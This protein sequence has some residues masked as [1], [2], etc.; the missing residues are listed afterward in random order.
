MAAARQSGVM[1]VVDQCVVLKALIELNLSLLLWTVSLQVV[2][3]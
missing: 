3:A 1:R 2:K